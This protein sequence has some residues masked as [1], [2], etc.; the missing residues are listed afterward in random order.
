MSHLGLELK[1][2]IKYF[3]DSSPSLDRI[4]TD[5]GYTPE[6]SRIISWRANKLKNDATYL[7]YERIYNFY[8]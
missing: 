4:N 3:V 6:N 1:R 5:Y 7:E 8:K 2:G